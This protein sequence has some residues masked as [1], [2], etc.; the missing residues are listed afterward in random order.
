MGRKRVK[1]MN[2]KS[3]R[4]KAKSKRSVVTKVNMVKG[5]KKGR[6]KSFDITTKKRK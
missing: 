4:K 1:A 6:T 2:V 3:A 5:T